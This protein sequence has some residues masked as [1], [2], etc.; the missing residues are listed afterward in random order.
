MDNGLYINNYIETISATAHD[1]LNNMMQLKAQIKVLEAVIAD[2]AGQIST[3]QDTITNLLDTKRANQELQN[4]ID[5]LAEENHGL[6]NKASQV[7][8]F[9]NE[10]KELKKIARN[11]K[12][13][14]P[15]KDDF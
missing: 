8:T 2:N 11:P 3:L 13:L 15:P 7:D 14:E 6:R 1:F 5:L 10:I 4:K 9:A 12:K